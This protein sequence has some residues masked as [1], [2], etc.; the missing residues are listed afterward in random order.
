MTLLQIRPTAGFAKAVN[1]VVARI[2]EL[3]Q[4]AAGDADWV[5]AHKTVEVEHMRYN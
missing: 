2:V 4:L 1:T 5:E 3:A